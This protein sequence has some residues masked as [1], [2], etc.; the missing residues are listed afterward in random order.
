MTK[1]LLKRLLRGLLSIVAVIMIVMI[2]VF[3]FS[4]RDRVFLGDPLYSRKQNNDQDIYKYAK[5]EEYGYLDYVRYTD[6]L[7]ELFEKGEITE[8]ARSAAVSISRKSKN[9]PAPVKKYV[10]QFTEYYESK[11]YT[12]VRLEATMFGN[13]LAPGG[14][15]QLFAYKNV[16]VFS[17]LASFFGNLIHIDNIHYVEDDIEDRGIKFTFYDPV[18]NTE[19]GTGE[20]VEKVFSPAIIGNGTQHK[21]LL[22]FDSNFPYIHQNLITVRLGKS[23][24]VAKGIDVFEYMN[25]PNG[26]AVYS[27][28]TYPSGL[29]EQGSENLHTAQYGLANEKYYSDNYTNVSGYKSHSSRMTMSFLVGLASSVLA[30]LVALPIGIMMARKKDKWLDKL[31]TFYIIFIMA[32][33][34]LAYILMLKA[35][36]GATGVLPTEWSLQTTSLLV[37]VLPVISLALPSIAGLMKWLRRYM[38]DQMNSDYVKFA[39]AGGLTEN[40]IF[41]KH[42]FKNAAI[43]IIHGIPGSILGSLVGAIITERVYYIPGVGYLLT[44]AIS[45]Y[46]NGVII[47][48]T[49]FYSLI[50]IISIILGDILMAIADPRI[51]FSSKAR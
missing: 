35:L 50:S 37:Y 33:P 31:G 16:S 28:M 41:S 51:S 11:G 22:Y 12:V 15:Q 17:R 18:Y 34:S 10:K 19:P 45:R 44:E 48:L 20:I 29:V 26:R 5:W 42:I 30:Y 38:I 27:E 4:N 8:E 43:P 32:C 23:Y 39:R 14:T 7:N 24:S 21:Y 46:D 40:E 49:L 3:T 36:G 25:T 1:Y 2:L 13:R 9:D 6:Y 47:G